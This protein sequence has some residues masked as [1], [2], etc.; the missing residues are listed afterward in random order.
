MRCYLHIV[1]MLTVSLNNQLHVS[2][3]K[4]INSLEQ[5]FSLEAN[6]RSASHGI[7]D[8]WNPKSHNCIT[9]SHHWTLSQVR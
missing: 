4:T 5:S 7:S 9:R 3:S 2:T 1:S 6:S 8:L